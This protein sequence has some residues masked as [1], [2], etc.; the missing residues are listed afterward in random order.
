MLED[1][2]IPL[3]NVTTI[4]TAGKTPPNT[5]Q[6]AEL[7]AAVDREKKDF[8]RRPYAWR[9]TT[10]R[11]PQCTFHLSLKRMVLCGPDTAGCCLLRRC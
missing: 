9:E 10:C 2:K 8:V 7:E 3:V 11:F 4:P 5:Q 6:Q 1:N